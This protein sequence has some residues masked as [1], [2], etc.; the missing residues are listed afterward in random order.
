MLA[1]FTLGDPQ[2]DQPPPAFM[3]PNGKAGL[4]N[5]IDPG[6]SRQKTDGAWSKCQ[7]I[8]PVTA[9]LG[10]QKRPIGLEDAGKFGEERLTLCLV[11]NFV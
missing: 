4:G 2:G 6:M 8:P 5:V 10:D 9:M 1:G 7:E 11:L 3:V